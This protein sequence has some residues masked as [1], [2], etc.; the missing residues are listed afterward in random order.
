MVK[1]EQDVGSVYADPR[2]LQQALLNV[3][4][5]ASD[6]LEGR[7]D[8]AIDITISKLDD[9]VRIQIHDNG[10]GISE[11]D[12]KTLFRPFVTSK[13]QGTG[14]G[15]VLVKKM[16]TKMNGGVMIT[17]RPDAGT[18]VDIMIPEGRNDIYEQENTSDH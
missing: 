1:V 10:S 12:Q 11:E 16:L 4:T 3:M 15:L 17:S 5:N 18:T 8:P 6:A 2:A 14:L 9:H 13:K 7:E